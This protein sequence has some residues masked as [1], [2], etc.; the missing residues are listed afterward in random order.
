VS[1]AASFANYWTSTTRM[2]TLP[3]VDTLNAGFIATSWGGRAETGYKIAWAPVNL[4]PYV[5]FQAQTYATPN[6]SESSASGSSAFALSYAGRTG[7]VERAEAGS[8]LSKNF[9]LA[10]NAIATA[11]GRAAYAHDWQNAPHSAASF[12]GLAPVASFVTNGAKPAADL[13]VVTAG[14]EIRMASG[15]ALMGKFDGEFGQGT[16]TYVGTARVRYAW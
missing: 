11:F 15:W 12:L 7:S 1:G 3:T 5:A 9:L 14:A 8:W 6:Y 2:I 16:Q 10:D 4:A 13:A